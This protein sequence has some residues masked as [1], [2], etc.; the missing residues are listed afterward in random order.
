MMQIAT[1]IL[2]VSFVWKE[3]LDKKASVCT[4]TADAQV[5]TEEKTRSKNQEADARCT[6]YQSTEER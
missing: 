3:V 5:D 4:Y 2:E 6:L 1:S